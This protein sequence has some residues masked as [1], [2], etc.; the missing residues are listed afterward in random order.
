MKRKLFFIGYGFCGKDNDFGTYPASAVAI[1]PSMCILGLW[2]SAGETIGNPKTIMLYA[3]NKSSMTTV[4]WM[5]P[6]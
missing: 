1:S 3:P 2:G 4:L 5:R 6:L